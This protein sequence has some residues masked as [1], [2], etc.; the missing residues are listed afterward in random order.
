MEEKSRNRQSN[1]E[2]EEQSE[3]IR[4]SDLKVYF[5]AIIIKSM[6]LT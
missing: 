5:K 2:K 1:L 6:I 3:G 4:L